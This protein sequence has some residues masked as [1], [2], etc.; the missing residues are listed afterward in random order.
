MASKGK[1]KNSNKFRKTFVDFWTRWIGNDRVL[2]TGDESCVGLLSNWLA[3]L[4]SSTFR[5]FRHTATTCALTIVTGLCVK[6]QELHVE[7]ATANRQLNAEQKKN[8]SARYEQLCKRVDEIQTQKLLVEKL[9]QDLY[10][11]VF[12][13]RYRD[14][15]A[16]IRMEC[17]RELGVWISR[18]P[19]CYLE[20]QHLRYIGWMLS[21]KAANVRHEAL[22][23]LNA[24]YA[25]EDLVAGLRTFSERF[26]KRIIEMGMTEK[27]I[28]VRHEA[29][30]TICLLS[31]SGLVED[32]DMDLIVTM[33]MD[34]DAKIRDAVAPLVADWWSESV[35]GPEWES[36]LPSI[37]EDDKPNFELKS[38][39]KTLFRIG[40]L[41]QKRLNVSS[42][43]S[44]NSEQAAPDSS[45]RHLQVD[46]SDGAEQI[47]QIRASDLQQLMLWTKLQ[48][49]DSSQYF[50]GF[51]NVYAA[52]SSLWNH[53][54]LLHN[55]DAMAEYLLKDYSEGNVPEAPKKKSKK[56][57]SKQMP[58]PLLLSEDDELCL[59]YIMSSSFFFKMSWFKAD[60]RQLNDSDE[61]ASSLS[62]SL[63]NYIPQ[64][65]QKYSI[66][67]T[68]N[69]K[70]CLV[71]SISLLRA[72]HL[73]IFVEAS[74]IKKFESLLNDIEKIYL[75]HSGNDF[76]RE[77][78]STIKYFL[79]A[80]GSD[81]STKPVGE[82]PKRRPALLSSSNAPSLLR[83]HVHK[84]LHSLADAMFF[85]QIPNAINQLN[86]NADCE[87]LQSL[88]DAIKRARELMYNI[89]VSKTKALQGKVASDTRKGNGIAE[90]ILNVILKVLREQQK[91]D[92]ELEALICAAA[93][94]AVDVAMFDLAFELKRVN[95]LEDD[96]EAAI[97][98]V[99]LLK[100]RCDRLVT[101]C[102]AMVVDDTQ[103]L[104]TQIAL[105][106]R[107]VF[108]RVLFNM[109]P[110]MNGAVAERYPE[111]QRCPSNDCVSEAPRIIDS[112]VKIV[113][114]MPLDKK[115]TPELPQHE[116]MVLLKHMIF[117]SLDC[118]RRLV[119]FG[120]FDR[121]ASAGI[122]K[123]MGLEEKSL[124]PWLSKTNSRIE[125]SNEVYERPTLDLFGSVWN[126]LSS[127]VINASIGDSVPQLVKAYTDLVDGGDAPQAIAVAKEALSDICAFIFKSVTGSIDLFY[128]MQFPTLDHSIALAK[129]IAV[130]MKHWG[131]RLSSGSADVTSAMKQLHNLCVRS[132]LQLICDG[133]VWMIQRIKSWKCVL[134]QAANRRVSGLT[135]TTISF[136]SGN[137]SHIIETDAS[138]SDGLLDW[139]NSD[140]E[141]GGSFGLVPEFKQI[142]EAWRVWSIIGGSIGH[143]IKGLY[144][145]VPKDALKSATSVTTIQAAVVYI[146]DQMEQEGIEPLSDD[147]AWTEY[148]NCIASYERGDSTLKR[149]AR[150]AVGAKATSRPGTPASTKKTR[151]A[152]QPSRSSVKRQAKAAPKYNYDSDTSKENEEVND[153]AVTPRKSTRAP[154]RASTGM[155]MNS[156]GSSPEAQQQ[157]EEDADKTPTKK[158]RNPTKTRRSLR[159]SLQDLQ[160]EANSG[161]EELPPSSIYRDKPNTKDTRLLKGKG[162]I[163]QVA[164]EQSDDG[165]ASSPDVKSSKRIKL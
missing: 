25:N 136:I 27:E 154:R 99:P 40:S 64:F 9:M 94:Y 58:S 80:D 17:I 149:R 115:G 35:V 48:D 140:S 100:S 103:T 150:G 112:L 117:K 137:Q 148:F 22:R 101:L 118:I 16:T 124:A 79:G 133:A 152:R 82:Q 95:D 127:A 18:N 49:D 130:C 129:A 69:G 7:A 28:F 37:S 85:K 132:L 89:D 141:C 5:P 165:F 163:K 131:V 74:N 106:M 76:L 123:Y 91:A 151:Q 153:E 54:A 157:S 66:D 88:T 57:S 63:I 75:A 13:H 156:G 97:E 116:Q 128:S 30:Q 125:A 83:T 143:L 62:E 107:W 71:E 39:A 98:D 53:L 139:L 164:D 144:V 104:S 121:S 23:S 15:D 113:T 60:G 122:V 134:Q 47:L 51:A 56:A 38:L 6:A 161:D 44:A 120:M 42:Q 142:N 145:Q 86:E 34:S 90:D 32:D 119:A 77:A 24:L 10:D 2:S 92:P 59:F 12:V 36:T 8:T 70:L 108:L 46:A 162:Q 155:K 1:A 105:P 68:G 111:F 20:T 160:E 31:S 114:F 109:Y 138:S 55:T 159:Q 45:V 93:Q 26:K 4:S 11:G 110:L 19:D 72:V 158:R 78:N 81:Q 43:A 14:T 33:I 146:A 3:T 41:V 61:T 126:G 84:M 102:E 147:A 135:D 21:D 96:S 29:A 73:P 67:Y 52:V 65:I 87:S 50:I